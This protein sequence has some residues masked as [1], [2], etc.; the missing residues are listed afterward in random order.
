M[1]PA[2]LQASGTAAWSS[3]APCHRRRGRLFPRLPALPAQVPH[4]DLEDG[5]HHRSRASPLGLCLGRV[6]CLLNG[7]CYGNVACPDC[8]A[9]EFPLL[10]PALAGLVK[11]GYQTAAGF[12]VDGTRKRHVG[13]DRARFSGR[14]QAGLRPATSSSRSDGQSLE[15]RDLTTALLRA[16]W[17]RGKNDVQLTVARRAAGFTELRALRPLDDRPASRPRSTNRSA[18]SCSVFPGRPIIPSAPRR[19][20]HGPVH[21]RLRASTASSTRCCAPTPRTGR[22]RHDAVAEHQRD[23]AAWRRRC[24]PSWS[25]GGLPSPSTW[26]TRTRR[27]G[28]RRM[29]AG[30]A[31]RGR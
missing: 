20:G 28:I 4:L 29:R 9:I 18:W 21:G 15:D 10:R 16:R 6:G 27:S 24:W 5:R 25:G 30:Q 19:I 1:V 7:C 23:R 11:R 17:P 22:L 2:I 8:P 3:T 26:R 14:R 31:N 12:T 13:R